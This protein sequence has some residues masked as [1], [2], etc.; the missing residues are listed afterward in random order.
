MMVS[1][2]VCNWGGGF[3][4][5][6]SPWKGLPVFRGRS[7]RGIL[8]AFKGP[9]DTEG[10]RPVCVFQDLRDHRGDLETTLQRPCQKILTVSCV[11]VV[12]ADTAAVKS[13]D[14]ANTTSGRAQL[15]NRSPHELLC[16]SQHLVVL[17]EILSLGS[18][19][20]LRFQPTA[21]LR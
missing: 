8:P 6:L 4:G 7:S 11:T 15:A 10:Y 12:P 20:W 9:S 18:W 19:S 21:G 17:S 3:L 16:T 5:S 13:G 2:R 14:F 1:H